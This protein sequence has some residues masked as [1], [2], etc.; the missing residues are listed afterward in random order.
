MGA[1]DTKES[2]EGT[3]IHK[4]VGRRGTMA[5]A[6]GFNESSGAARAQ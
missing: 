2:T 5:P 6:R 4:M 3:K 1:R